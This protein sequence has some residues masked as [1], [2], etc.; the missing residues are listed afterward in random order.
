MKKIVTGFFIIIITVLLFH[1]YYVP[2]QKINCFTQYGPCSPEVVEQ[3]ENLK[4]QRVG[5][6]SRYLKRNLG[7]SEG[8]VRAESVYKF[9]A[10]IAVYLEQNK[11]DVAVRINDQQELVILD[12]NGNKM[13]IAQESQLPVLRVNTYDPNWEEIKHASI[14]LSNIYYW[15][16]LKHADMDGEKIVISQ[17][18]VDFYFPLSGDVDYQLGSFALILSWLNS[19]HQE[20]KINNEGGSSLVMDLRYNN[21]IIRY[22]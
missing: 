15:N 13:G 2:I 14:V 20:I 8:F 10:A 1:E 9:P 19:E 11:G 18:G 16:G 22:E 21:P 17:R 4:G 7:S 3:L 5:Q 12:Q 6:I